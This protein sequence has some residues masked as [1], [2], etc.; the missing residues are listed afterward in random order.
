MI[1]SPLAVARL[2][3]FNYVA[4]RACCN[5]MRLVELRLYLGRG[6]LIATGIGQ[7]TLFQ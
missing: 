3:G 5:P 2:Q 6:L 7:R 1:G 4:G